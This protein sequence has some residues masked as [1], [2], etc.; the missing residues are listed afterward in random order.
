[1]VNPLNKLYGDTQVRPALSTSYKSIV[2]VIFCMVWL[3]STTDLGAQPFDLPPQRSNL[4]AS[5]LLP[6]YFEFGQNNISDG[7]FLKTALMPAVEF[8]K[9]TVQ[10]GVRFD[11]ISNNKDV[12]SGV[13]LTGSRNILIGSFPLEVQALYIRTGYLDIL[14]ETNWGLLLKTRLKHLKVSMGT[15]FRTLALN[16]EVAENLIDTVNTKIHENWNMIYQFSYFI[17]P[18]GNNWNINF[19]ITNLDY[20]NLNQETN[21]I[22]KIGAIY[23]LSPTLILFIDSGYQS[24]GLTNMNTDYFGFFF[25]TGIIWNI[26]RKPC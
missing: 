12:L 3:I 25:K 16:K 5:I 17:K 18:L 15:S 20:F 19:S 4:A 22:L 26:W 6:A 2:F 9:N 1:M 7:I 8:L 11:I 21:P 14:H 13:S 10:A 24:S 23:D